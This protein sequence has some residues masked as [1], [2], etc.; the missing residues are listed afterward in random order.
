M[1]SL[2]KSAI[3]GKPLTKP[4]ASFVRDGAIETQQERA[5]PVLNQI[6]KKPHREKTLS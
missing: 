5:L 1:N 4:E 2:D 6:L 3:S